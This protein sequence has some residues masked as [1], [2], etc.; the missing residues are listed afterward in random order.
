MNLQHV[1]AKLFVKNREQVDLERL[2]PVFH[3][4][5]RDR[6][7]DELLLDVAD[8]RHVFEGPGVA[9]IGH[10][11]NYS[12]DNEDN[13]LGVRYNRKAALEG[14]NQ[15]RLEQ[16]T[17]AA[18]TALQRLEQDTRLD[19]QLQFG[20]HEIELFINDRLL[21]PNTD[22]TRE[23]TKEDFAE[24]AK[25]LFRGGEYSLSQAADPRRLFGWTL[26]ASSPFT[27]AE[28]LKNLD[29]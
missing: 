25:R 5:I 8:Y 10:E 6:V 12:V 24:F 18:L 28:L 9:V 7:F 29:S 17:R 23:A 1:N 3:S 20:G 16:S 21:A 4:W 14:S 19:G 27:V 15:D 13:R 11:A 2:I 22:A 26:K